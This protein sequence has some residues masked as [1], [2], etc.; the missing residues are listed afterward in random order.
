MAQSA[1]RM[2][3]T[4]S[5]GSTVQIDIDASAER[6]WALVARPGWYI[7]QGAVVSNPVLETDGDL[8]VL[9][10]PE[11]GDCR[12]RTVSLDPPR[13]AAFRWL[14]EGERVHP[15]G[16][17]DHRPGRM[18]ASPSGWSRAVSSALG[19]DPDWVVAQARGERRRAGSRSW[20]RPRRTLD[21]ARVC[22]GP[23]TSRRRPSR[24]GRCSPP[25]RDWPRGTPSTA[26]PWSRWSGERLSFTGPS[27]API[28]GRVEVAYDEPTHVRLPA[29]RR[30]RT[31]EP[32][33]RQHRGV[34]SRSRRA[35]PGSTVVVRHTGFAGWIRSLGDP[36]ALVGEEIQGWEG[37]LEL[38]ADLA[39]RAR[40][41]R[42]D[43]RDPQ[44]GVRRARRRDPLA[45][46]GPAGERP[47][48]ASAAGPR[49]PD[50]PA[51]RSCKHLEVLR[52]VGLVEVEHRGRE[53]VY[54]PLGGRLSAAGSRAGADRRSLGR[55]AAPDQGA[56]RE[57]AAG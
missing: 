5:T 43:E 21:R 49:P 3:W 17:L 26:R 38:L 19:D 16:V 41:P 1:A 32:T 40:C 56:R 57:P 50:Q 15:G 39:D 42:R 23:S 22:T 30:R 29:W 10:H 52:A 2:R 51:G 6:V 12:I 37:G 14:G 34:R 44:P 9:R 24:C 31:R 36:D 18:P 4:S 48:S 28:C 11:H 54:T 33:R 13:Y 45:D 35:G 20:P 47:A 7:N 55:P 8:T 25:P 53:M 27:T 46:P